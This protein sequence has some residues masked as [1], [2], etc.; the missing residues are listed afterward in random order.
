MVKFLIH[1]GYVNRLDLLHKALQ[2]IKPFWPATVV[3]DNSENRDLRRD[4][5]VKSN[6]EVYEPPIPLTFPQKMNYMQERALKEKCDVVMTMHN[7]AEA[8][9][10]TP[11]ALMSILH[12]WK[13]IGKKWGIA[14]TN[15]DVLAAFNMEAVLATGP[16]DTTMPQYFS[17]IDYYRRVQNAGFEHIFTGLGVVHHNDGMSTVKSDSYRKAVND[18]TWPLYEQYYVS[19]WGLGKWNGSLY[20]SGGFQ[21]P[22]NL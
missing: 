19:K 18:A 22:F 2:S 20:Q 13:W 16:W 9:P 12:G 15:F 4:Q 14:F 6:V 10:G 11:E 7:D 3:I 21:R 1:I 17:D 8:H 5:F